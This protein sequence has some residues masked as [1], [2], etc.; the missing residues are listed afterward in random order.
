MFGSASFCVL[1]SA[2]VIG[3]A[4]R[5]DMFACMY[6]CMHAC[7][8]ACRHVCHTVY[9]CKHICMHAFMVVYVCMYAGSFALA[10]TTFLH[11]MPRMPANWMHVCMCA[12][13]SVSYV[14]IG[15]Y[16]CT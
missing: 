2:N 12:C 15:V 1:G 4:S 9:E 16:L 3:S 13:V 14:W 5:R 10:E 8:H 7:M 11:A 6:V